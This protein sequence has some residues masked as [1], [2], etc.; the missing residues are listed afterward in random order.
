MLW[1]TPAGREGGAELDMHTR[2]SYEFVHP[3]EVPE[4]EPG[5]VVMP[6]GD[7]WVDA[8]R[9]IPRRIRVPDQ[10]LE[11]E[12][13]PRTDHDIVISPR[14]FGRPVSP[15][16]APLEAPLPRG[17]PWIRNPIKPAPVH[18]PDHLPLPPNWQYGE[19]PLP[20]FTIEPVPG[21][22]RFSRK[23][24]NP[25]TERRL[26]EKP[27][28]RD[29]KTGQRGYVAALWVINSTW[30]KYTEMLDLYGAYKWNLLD[31]EGNVAAPRYENPLE[32][33]DAHLRG[34]LE[35]DVEGFVTDFA[36]QQITDALAAKMNKYQGVYGQSNRSTDASRWSDAYTEE[37]ED[38]AQLS[39]DKVQQF[40]GVSAHERWFSEKF[41][42]GP[43]WL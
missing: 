27:R 40:Q 38:G 34:E 42:H 35:L 33:F 20:T 36:F 15:R 3:L 32:L 22:F 13:K 43:A 23:R 5:A 14:P 21:G 6:E 17:K 30:G 28:G 24:A 41:L 25:K 31:K 39:E 1:P 19:R 4:I 7:V 10:P 37:G 16:K 26:S 11:I 9:Q 29:Y 12:V 18:M 8:P 2:R